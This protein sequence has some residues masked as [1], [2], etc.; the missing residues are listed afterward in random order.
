V[1]EE[2]IDG[3]VE[4]I[5]GLVVVIVNDLLFE[6][7]PKSLNETKVW[8]VGRHEMKSNSEFYG[9]IL[10]FPFWVFPRNQPCLLVRKMKFFLQNRES[11]LSSTI[12]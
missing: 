5:K 8:S 9:F 1:K 12:I 2:G 10:D 7:F 4:K 11:Q 6:E 3:L